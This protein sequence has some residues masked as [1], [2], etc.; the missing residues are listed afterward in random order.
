VTV[1]LPA[2]EYEFICTV[3][4]HADAG[5]VGKLIVQ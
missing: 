3:A 5:M 1:N 4:G 2:G